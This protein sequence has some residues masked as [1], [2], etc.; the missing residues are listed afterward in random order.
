MAFHCEVYLGEQ[1]PEDFEPRNAPPLRW[2]RTAILPAGESV[3]IDAV[4]A[5]GKWS[6]EDF[7]TFLGHLP[8]FISSLPARVIDVTVFVNLVD[9][10]QG[11]WEIDAKGLELVARAGGDLVVQRHCVS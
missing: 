1:L 6:Y 5:Q 3:V 7:I 8:A 11:N 9:S 2:R 4:R 10:V